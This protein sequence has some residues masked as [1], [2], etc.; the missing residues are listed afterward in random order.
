MQLQKGD[1]VIVNDL[2]GVLVD[3]DT[4]MCKIKSVS[5]KIRSVNRFAVTQIC[6][7]SSMAAIFKRKLMIRIN[8]E[9]D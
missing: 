6:S 9:K 2:L 5:G 8:N 4:N 7:G 1:Y 3:L